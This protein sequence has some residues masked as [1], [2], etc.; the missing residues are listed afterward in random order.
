MDMSKELKAFLVEC[1][2]YSLNHNLNNLNN[3]NI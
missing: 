3:L 1:N 2:V